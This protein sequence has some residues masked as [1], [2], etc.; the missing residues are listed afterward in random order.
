MT[1][2]PVPPTESERG[3]TELEEALRDPDGTVAVVADPFFDREAVLDHAENALDATRGR[4]APAAGTLPDFSARP[5]VVDDCH[6]LYARRVGGFDPLDRFL[7]RLAS[8]SG[9]VVTSWNR[10]SW[11]YLDA[12]RG[13]GDTFR[14]VR[15]L[16]SLSTERIA[17]AIRDRREPLP[18]FETTPGRGDSPLT[19]R[20]ATPST[21]TTSRW[22]P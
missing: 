11:N 7:E 21:A 4:L 9:P 16:P 8:A 10:Y 20:F 19:T 3:A 12:V 2:T 13:L 15:T 22:R 14:H 6:H 1:T 18:T 5:V 17:A